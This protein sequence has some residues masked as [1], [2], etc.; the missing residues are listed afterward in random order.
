VQQFNRATTAWLLKNQRYIR[1]NEEL[2]NFQYLIS[3]LEQ[4]FTQVNS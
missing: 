1:V 4:D 2:E 3:D